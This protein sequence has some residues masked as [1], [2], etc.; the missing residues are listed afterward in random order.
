MGIYNRGWKLSVGIPKVLNFE[1]TEDRRTKSRDQLATST[2]DFL[3]SE[4]VEDFAKSKRV[5]I[6]KGRGGSSSPATRA[7]TTVWPRTP[8]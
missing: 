5:E 2:L 7:V 3:G 1:V 4:A 8:R 6:A